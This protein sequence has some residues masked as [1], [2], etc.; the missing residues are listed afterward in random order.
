MSRTLVTG[1]AGSIGRELVPLLRPLGVVLAT[2]IGTFDVTKTCRLTERFDVVYHLA[3]AKQA[4]VGESD[5]AGT[6]VVNAQGT[7]NVIAAF[8]GAKIILAS[9]CKA[10][11]PETVYGASKLI[12]ER[13]VLNAG[14]VVLR[15][16][17]VRETGGNV[18]R[19]WEGLPTSEPIPYTDCWRYFIT[20][21]QALDLTVAA[22]DLPSGRYTVDPGEPSHMLAEAKR[23][24]PGRALIPIA[25]R[26]GDRI[27]EPLHATHEHAVPVAD[28]PGLLEIVNRHDLSAD[29]DLW[30][31]WFE[32]RAAV[33]A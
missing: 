25:P 18:F 11:N 27:R 14:G 10:C 6:F 3:G 12:A 26:R 28:H 29:T 2:D 22:V 23:L 13:M 24:Y 7:A 8:P 20:M 15:Y 4:P 31:E 9:T 32:G 30:M 19:F 17:N 33:A 1:A 21:R 16:F 5:P